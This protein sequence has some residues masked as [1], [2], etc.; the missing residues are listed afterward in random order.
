MKINM[1]RLMISQEYKFQK[2]GSVFYIS[3]G[4][5][6]KIKLSTGE[7]CE[8]TLVEVGGLSQCFDIDTD[9]GVITIDCENVIDI[10]PI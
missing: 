3:E 7:I 2:G 10:M 5:G 8:G 1:E 9:N 4:H 6:L